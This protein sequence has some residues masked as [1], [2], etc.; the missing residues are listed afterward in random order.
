MRQTAGPSTVLHLDCEADYPAGVLI[1]NDH[2]PVCLQGS[3][4]GPKEIDA[5]QAVLCV[6]AGVVSQGRPDG[7]LDLA[8]CLLLANRADDTFVS[9]VRCEMKAG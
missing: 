9:S 8:S 4:F 2:D 6:T 7:Y 5:P 1:H 3:R